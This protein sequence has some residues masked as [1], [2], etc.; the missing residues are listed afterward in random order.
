MSN[1]AVMA[2]AVLGCYLLGNISPAIILGKIIAKIDIRKHGSGN[3]GTTNVLRTL[4]AKAAVA[5]LLIDILKGVSA[6]LIGRYLGGQDL[7]MLCGLAA[8]IGHIWPVVYGFKGG[9]GI[10][11]AAG[12]IVCVEPA[13]GAV[14]VAI[15]L[16]IIAATRRVSVGALTAALIFPFAAN[17]F[18]PKY[19]SWAIIISIIIVIKHRANIKRLLAGQEPKL[20]F[21]KK[22]E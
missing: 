7:A 12:V 14:M 22:A 3:A 20:S 8:F 6:V 18:D 15:A 11:T 4:G 1:T 19:L 2:F 13:L 17:Y 21:K 10:A 9:K 5:T 16:L